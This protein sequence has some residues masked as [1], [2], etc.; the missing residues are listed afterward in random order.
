VRR[1]A[2][3]KTA[4]YL[5]LHSA[6]VSFKIPFRLFISTLLKKLLFF[7]CNLF[8]QKY[9]KRMKHLVL[10]TLM[11]II[12][13]TAKSQ[14][15]YTTVATG[16][17]TSSATWSGGA[18]GTPAT[19]TAAT[20]FVCNCKIVVSSGTNLTID[21]DVYLTNAKI[22]LD[23]S[24]SQLTFSGGRDL[25]LFGTSS[26]DIQNTGAS[27]N[28]TNPNSFIRLGTTSPGTVIFQGNTTKFPA[29][30]P[31]GTV[32][33]L[34]SAASTRADPQFQNGTLPV[35]LSDFRVATK[36]NSVT[37]TWK[38]AFEVNSSHFEIERSSDGKTWSTKGSVNAAGNVSVDQSYSFTDDS[39][40]NGTNHYRLKIVDIDARF[41]YS[42]IKT[43]S[44]ASTALNVVAGPNPAYSFLNVNVTTPGSEPYRLR[45]INRSG[46]VVFDQK[47]AASSNKLQLS[48]S[49]YVDGTYF[50]EVTN[51]SGLRQINKV[52]I[53]RK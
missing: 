34:A 11:I 1:L 25:N 53:V 10:F 47:Y 16:S 31:A 4:I 52:M 22:I 44:F 32:Q 7:P 49:N 36:L 46:Q 17:Y 8:S 37:L 13:A 19:G 20:P 50:L 21:A 26:I 48:V 27:V 41:E 12:A 33:G 6:S 18:A 28:S 9:S 23:G 2:L 15:I 3:F 35:K 14:T 38:T 51:N 39:P 5:V 40:E 24:G 30:A 45:L 29:S 42:P 43:V